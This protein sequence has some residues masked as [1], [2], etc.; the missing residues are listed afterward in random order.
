VPEATVSV[1]ALQMS[2]QSVHR[3]IYSELVMDKNGL[4][5]MT[6]G[7]DPA[8]V[9]DRVAEGKAIEGTV[10]DLSHRFHMS[11]VLAFGVGLLVSRVGARVVYVE[12]RHSI[13]G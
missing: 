3:R 12:D 11:K 1:E 4:F 9:E 2:P 6:D 7:R 8:E 13:L 5:D 10:L